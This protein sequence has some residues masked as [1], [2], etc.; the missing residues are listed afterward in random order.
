MEQ[1]LAELPRLPRGDIEQNWLRDVFFLM[2]EHVLGKKATVRWSFAETVE[3]AVARV[4]ED[5]PTFTP[6]IL[7]R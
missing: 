7:E 5:Y 4:R 6:T 3:W 2:R 1:A